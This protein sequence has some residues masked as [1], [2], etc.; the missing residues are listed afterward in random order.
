MVARVLVVDDVD[1]NGRLLEAKLTIE[2]YEVLT[3][4][5]GP[6]AIRVAAEQ[7]PD[8]ILLDVMMPGM[9]G[10]E[11][12]RR[13]KADPATS[14]IPVVLVTAL[15]GR[16][17]RIVGLDA[18]ADDFVAKPIDDVLLFA[19]VRSLTR[20]KLIM[21]EL[22]EREES[23]RRL[24]VSADKAGKL[25]RSGGRILIVDDN[26]RQAAKMVEVLSKE[27]RPV[28]ESDPTAGLAAA[29]GLNDLL[30]VNVAASEFDGLRLVAQ[31]RSTESTRH[32]PILAV[33][34]PADRP[35][36]VKALELGVTDLLTKPVDPE[37]LAARART[38][39]RRKRYT[40]FL[41]EKLDYSL[42]MAVT[43]A[44]TGLHNRRY[45]AGQLQAF[46]SRAAL[47]GEPVSVLVL[48]IDHFKAVNDG[49]GHVAGDEVLREFA[50]RLATNVRAVDL[51]CRLGGEEFVV[52]M[53]G[54]DM[55]DARRIAERIRRDVGSTPFRVMGGRELLTVTISIGVAACAGPG[56]TPESLLK[57]ADEGVYAA[58]AAGRDRVVA[59]AA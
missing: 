49:F 46:V 15:D 1:A 52:V 34:D 44:L 8:I 55:E 54:T 28:V 45:M 4:S 13:I 22:R 3:A 58:K 20:L 2:Y 6:T 41:R 27:H 23:S 16:E 12:C 33:V 24:G 18:G 42:E 17:D 35:R 32:L 43:D 51:P 53:P 57:R 19:R 38:Q 30:I 50:V 26:A 36:L 56:D 47:G 11:T 7:K 29:R 25:K 59:R 31:V 39:V 10:F 37:E 14:H 9:D 40:D 5:D 48:D 21:D